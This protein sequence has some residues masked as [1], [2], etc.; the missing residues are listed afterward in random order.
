MRAF[1]VATLCVLPVVTHANAGSTTPASFIPQRD[2]GGFLARNL[3]LASFRNS[4][5]PRRT[6]AQRTFASLGIT[7]TS[8]SGHSVVFEEDDWTYRI[9]ILR[10]GDINRDGLEDLEICFTDKAKEGSY[11]TQQ[12]MLVTRYS[13]SSLVTALHYE[14]DGCPAYAK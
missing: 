3:D 8:T 5:G 10:R 13:A 7:P 14:V 9:K 11:A 12:P 4:L 6:P 1:L 2:V